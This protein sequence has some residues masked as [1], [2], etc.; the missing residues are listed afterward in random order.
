MTSTDFKDNFCNLDKSHEKYGVVDN[1]EDFNYLKMLEV[2]TFL[3]QISENLDKWKRI[4]IISYYLEAVIS[5][6]DKTLVLINHK[7]R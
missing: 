4:G 6:G 1:L 3:D 5:V 2:N 7:F